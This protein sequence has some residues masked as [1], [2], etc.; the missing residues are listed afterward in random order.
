MRSAGVV[1]AAPRFD[2]PARHRHAA[3]DL[4]VEALVP[5]AA[6]EARDKGIL[7][8]LSGRDVVPSGV[9]F[10]LSVQDGMRSELGGVVADDHQR[11]PAGRDDGIELV[12]HPSAGDRR[13][14]DQCQAL[15]GK[16]VDLFAS[17]ADPSPEISLNSRKNSISYG[18][19]G[20]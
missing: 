17:G 4:F 2:D 12:R 20:D 13:V 6:V 5:A 16:V 10:L 15:A 9:A 14:D 8:R 19:S 1:I 7:D 3:A 11:L 18:V